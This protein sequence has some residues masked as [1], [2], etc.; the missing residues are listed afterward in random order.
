MRPE[1]RTETVVQMC[2][3]MRQQND[4]SACPILADALQDAGCDDEVL[5]ALLRT[6]MDA[7]LL[8]RLVAIVYSTKTEKAVE[9]MEQFV[10]DINYKDYDTDEDYIEIPGTR[11]E[12]NTEPHTYKYVIRMVTDDLARNDAIC[13]STDEGTEYFNYGSEEQN[14]D[15]RMTFFDAFSAI[16]GINV[17]P[18]IA[19]DYIIQCAC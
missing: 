13:F 3:G 16:T 2:E 7:I 10:R 17:P 8:Q 1:W 18:E 15:R 4:Y 14:R 19:I 9:W 12:N 5:L 6:E 11:K